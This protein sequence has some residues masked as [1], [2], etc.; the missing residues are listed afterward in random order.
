MK[1]NIRL[2][3]HRKELKDPKVILADKLFQK[4]GH[5]FNEHARFTIIDRLAN[6]NI[7]KEILRE[8]VI[9][10]KNFWIQKIESLYPK[11]LNQEPNM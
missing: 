5:R 2:S 6:T 9:Q 10:R 8:C 4:N 11:V 7:D 3:N 1:I